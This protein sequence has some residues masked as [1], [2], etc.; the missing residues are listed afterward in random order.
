MPKNTFILPQTGQ[1]ALIRQRRTGSPKSPT[2]AKGQVSHPTEAKPW[3]PEVNPLNIIFA[4]TPLK[5]RTTIKTFRPVCLGRGKA[6]GP[7]FNFTPRLLN[8]HFQNC[9]PYA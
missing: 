9:H 5:N 8:H 1:K 3:A 2:G 6:V 4:Q 7:V